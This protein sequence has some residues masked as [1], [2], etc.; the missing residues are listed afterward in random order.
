MNNNLIAQTNQLVR[1][2]IVQYRIDPGFHTKSGIYDAINRRRRAR[3]YVMPK[4][5]RYAWERLSNSPD[6]SFSEKC[7]IVDRA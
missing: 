5:K 1:A 7:A 4:A 6:L 2:A 3:D